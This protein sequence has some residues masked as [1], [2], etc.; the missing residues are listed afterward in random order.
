MAARPSEVL[1]SLLYYA[2]FYLG[3]VFLVFLAFASI[4]LGRTAFLWMVDRWTRFH[5]ACVTKLLGIKI[6]IRGELPRGGALIAMKHESFFEA[7]DLPVMFERPVVFA[8]AELMAI[9]IWG[10]AARA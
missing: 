3:S 9:P 10:R 8:K 1:R 6:V 2:V 5:R 4:L 7:L